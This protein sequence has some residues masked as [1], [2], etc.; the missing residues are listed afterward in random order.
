[1]KWTT[2]GHGL[3]GGGATLLT[4]K[5]RRTSPTGDERHN[6]RKSGPTADN[7]KRV[8]SPP[9]GT[10]SS[11]PDVTDAANHNSK[12][13]S[14]SAGGLAFVRTRGIRTDETSG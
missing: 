12:P 3:P 4:I 7:L 14:G 8:S 10:I 9:V 13:R 6:K 5:S 2:G 1:M 11:A